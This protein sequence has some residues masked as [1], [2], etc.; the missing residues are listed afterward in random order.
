MKIKAFGAK[1]LSKAAMV[2]SS[3]WIASLTILKGF[4]KINLDI[5]TIISSGVAITAV[6]TPTFVSIVTDK[7]KEKV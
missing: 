7:I 4:G 5:G 6:W 2:F 3:L 1:I